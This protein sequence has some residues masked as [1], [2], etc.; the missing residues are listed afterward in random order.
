MGNLIQKIC[1]KNDCV[2][3]GS[4]L[5]SLKYLIVHSPGVYP[6]IVR[7][8][9]GKNPWCDR[10]NKTGVEKMVNGFIDDTGAYQTAP[11]DLACWQV[12]TH[13]GNYNAIGFEL[14]ELETQAEFEK[15]WSNAV[16]VYADLCQEY[17]MSV[18]QI[19][20]HYEAHAAGFASNHADPKTYF[21]RF[22]KTMDDFRADVQ[23]VLNGNEAEEPAS[24]ATVSEIFSPWKYAKVCNLTADDPY[25]NVRTG[26]G[27]QYDVIRQL[28]NGNEVDV[29]EM[30]TNGWAKINIVGQIGYVNARWLDMG[31]AQSAPDEEETKDPETTY[32]VGK[33]YTLQT[34]LNVRIGP[35]TS[36]RQKQRSELT[37]DGQKNAKAGSMAVLKKGTKVTAKEVQKDG[38]ENTWLRIPSGWVCAIYQREIYIS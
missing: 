10:W 25:L 27:T 36:Y 16:R 35:G 8:A 6:A 38:S 17:G 2:K 18:S 37:A 28:A 29:L 3:Q 9:S 20:G 7:A 22:G 5:E 26:P 13:E 14:C 31:A 21:G 15:V 34:N 24:S 1:T 19:Y 32:Q 12:G 11:L 30:Y 23:A 4:K 33:V